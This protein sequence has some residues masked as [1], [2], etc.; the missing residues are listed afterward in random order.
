V[1]LDGEAQTITFSGAIYTSL[2]SE[3]VNVDSIQN[4]L[5]SRLDEALIKGDSEI[6]TAG[7]KE[8]KKANYR[9]S[10]NRAL[11]LIEKNQTD[12]LKEHI[13]ELMALVI[14]LLRFSDQELKLGME[15][16]IEALLERLKSR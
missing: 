16:V 2:A 5:E 4:E 14:P 3:T 1:T 15:K 10:V 11:A 9:P 12:D 6:V 8:E 7:Y 13:K